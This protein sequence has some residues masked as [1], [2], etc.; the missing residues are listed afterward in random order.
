MS[1]ETRFHPEDIE[2]FLLNKDYGDLTSEERE[3]VSE[4]ISNEEEY[5]LM[6]GTLSNIAE[7]VHPDV[8]IVAPYAIKDA[9]MAEF[10]KRYNEALDI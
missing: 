7:T 9:L 3:F 10:E 1:T 8:E 2:H 5:L 6:R 4:F